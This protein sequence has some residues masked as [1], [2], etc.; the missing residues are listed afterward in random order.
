MT[1]I[2]GPTWSSCARYLGLLSQISRDASGSAK[3]GVQSSR[4]TTCGGAKVNLQGL[5]G[6]LPSYNA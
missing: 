4:T 5:V 6:L 3:A 2:A 1:D